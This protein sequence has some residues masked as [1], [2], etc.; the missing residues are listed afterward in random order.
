MSILHKVFEYSVDGEINAAMHYNELA[1]RYFG[2]FAC[3]N[4]I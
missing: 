3:L 4:N 1:K 2:E